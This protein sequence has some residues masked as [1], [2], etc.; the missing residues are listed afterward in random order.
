MEQHMTVKTRSLEAAADVQSLLRARNNLLVIVSRE[1]SRVE[2]YLFEAAA[3]AGY[4]ARFWDVAQGVTELS[5]KALKSVG[6]N[7]PGEMLTFIS[8]NKGERAVWVMRDLL[9]WLA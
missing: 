7:D 6:A 1:E 2:R 3:A 9:V 4:I 8:N 5:G